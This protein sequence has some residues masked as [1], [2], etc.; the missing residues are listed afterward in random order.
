[1]SKVALKAALSCTCTVFLLVVGTRQIVGADFLQAGM[2]AA[3]VAIFCGIASF[4]AW[5][6]A[7]PVEYADTGTMFDD[8]VGPLNDDRVLGYT[9]ASMLISG[10]LCASIGHFSREVFTVAFLNFI[11]SGVVGISAMVAFAFRDAQ[12]ELDDHGR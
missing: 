4:F 9:L 3:I 12:Q 8:L 1:M 10:V 5:R 2:E 7:F 11:Y 6:T